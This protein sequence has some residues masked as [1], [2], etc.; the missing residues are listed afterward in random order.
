M[1]LRYYNYFLKFRHPFVLSVG[2]RTETP[3]VYVELEEDGETGYG[4]A[5]LP[6]YLPETQ[7]SVTTYLERLNLEKQGVEQGIEA[8]HSYLESTATGNYFAKAALDIAFHDLLG[9]KKK[10][11][12]SQLWDIE[13]TKEVLCT[14]T[15]GISDDQDT[16][17]Q[18]IKE[19]NAFRLFKIKLGSG[20]D[21]ENILRLRQLTEKPFTVDVNQGWTDKYF[22]LDMIGWLAE[23]NVILV[24]QPMPKSQWDD[25]AWVTSRSVIPT[26]ADESLQGLKDLPAIAEAFSGLN[27][28]LMKCGGLYEAKRIAELAVSKKMKVLLGCMSESS[29]GVSAA[30][31]LT[32]FVDWADLDGP[33]LISNDPFIGMTVDKGFIKVPEG[34]GIGVHKRV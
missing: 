19:G 25:M 33:Y 17:E 32:P 31:H 8:F 27:I 16:L 20:K 12:L 22:T 28:K 2:S 18:K 24:E 30:S 13:E 11:S 26:I 14:Y 7:Q 10:K 29:C 1:K 15:I 21:K 3:V 23:Q 9:K 4:E 6:P 5:T 34:P